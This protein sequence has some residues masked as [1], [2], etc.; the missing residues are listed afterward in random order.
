ML[1]GQIDYKRTTNLYNKGMF[2]FIA[3]YSKV[4]KTPK[5]TFWW[6]F[7]KENEAQ[8][9][10]EFCRGKWARFGLSISKIYQI[11]YGD[12]WAIPWLDWKQEWTDEKF[13]ELIKATPEEIAFVNE[14]IP[15]YY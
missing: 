5:G 9:F 8:N 15:K 10:Y 3:K 11:N 4:T 6:S 7:K 1:G 13:E 14:K 2:V 12:V